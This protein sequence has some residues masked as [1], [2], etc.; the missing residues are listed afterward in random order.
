M[1]ETT[2]EF[3]EAKGAEVIAERLRVEVGTVRVWKH[4]KSI[5]RATWPELI[6][7]FPE[8]TLDRLKAMEGRSP[9]QDAHGAAA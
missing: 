4:R 8:L 7:A 1:S 5:P 2:A 6:E 9:T 3:I